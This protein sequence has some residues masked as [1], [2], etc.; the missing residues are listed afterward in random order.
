MSRR[1]WASGVR[2]SRDPND[3]FSVRLYSQTFLSKAGKM[4]S[5]SHKPILSFCLTKEERSLASSMQIWSLREQPDWSYL[6]L[7]AIPPP[8]TMAG[9]TQITMALCSEQGWR[10]QFHSSYMEGILHWKAGF[11]FLKKKGGKG[12]LERQKKKKK[13]DIHANNSFLTF[14]L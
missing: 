3:E 7:T 10:R 5:V 14:L 8:T 4:S 13:K 12:I 6:I 1:R 2:K 9:K 11:S